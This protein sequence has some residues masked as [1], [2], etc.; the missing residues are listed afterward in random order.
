LDALAVSEQ[1]VGLNLF[2]RTE[3]EVHA[4]AG[5]DDV[6]IPNAVA[7]AG[8]WNVGIAQQGGHRDVIGEV[9]LEAAGQFHGEMI[10]AIAGITVSEAQSRVEERQ[11]AHVG[12]GT[13]GRAKRQRLRPETIFVVIIGE[14]RGQIDDHENPTV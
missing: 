8:P 13:E 2:E 9:V 1:M 10:P 14:G 6:H 4:Y 12:L 7:V 3:V 11:H 5:L